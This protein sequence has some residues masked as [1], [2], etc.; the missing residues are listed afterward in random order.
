V[1]RV[2]GLPGDTI[3]VH[4]GVVRLNGQDLPRQQVGDFDLPVSPNSPCDRKGGS[5]R[6]QTGGD[7]QP[8]CLYPRFRETLPGG[9]AYDVL[10]QGYSIADNFGPVTVPEGRLFMMGDNRDD[11]MDSRFS[12]ESGGVGLLPIENVLG[13]AMIGFWSTDG[14]AQWLLP[15]TW[16]T[17]ARW[18]RIFETY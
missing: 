17:A 13:R 15:W 5:V 1:K 2:I 6:L 18:S 14:S 16:F 7:G 9:R 3:E 12:V 11:S 10:D 8:H 4:A